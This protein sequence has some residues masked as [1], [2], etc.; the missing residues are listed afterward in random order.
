MPPELENVCALLQVFDM[1]RSI[2]FYRQVLGFEIVDSAPPGENFDWCWLRVGDV[3]LMLNTM[4]EAESRPSSPDSDRAAAHADVALY[5]SCRDLD[6]AFRHVR[7]LGLAA[8]PPIVRAYG[9]RQLCF[10]DPDGY[11]VCLQWPAV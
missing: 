3:H 5:F 1:P 2:A 9:M 7:D 4:Y 8:E 11:G 10:R 6:A